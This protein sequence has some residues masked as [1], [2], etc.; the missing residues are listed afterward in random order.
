MLYALLIVKKAAVIPRGGLSPP[1]G[2]D[3]EII[4]VIKLNMHFIVFRIN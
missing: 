4:R 1:R 2:F 3:L